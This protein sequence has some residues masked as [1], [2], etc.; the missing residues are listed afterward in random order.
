METT[1]NESLTGIVKRRRG[2]PETRNREA[3]MIAIWGVVQRE[4]HVFGAPSV[5]RACEIIFERAGGLIK[6]TDTD[7]RVLDVIVGPGGA[8]TLRQRYQ[9]AE[10]CRHNAERYPN[11]HRKAEQLAKELPGTF[12]RRKAALQ[13]NRDWAATGFNPLK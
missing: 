9:T 8:A 2:R 1:R 6:V 11:L 12:A 7:G 4:I 3:L 13:A 5:R 10:R